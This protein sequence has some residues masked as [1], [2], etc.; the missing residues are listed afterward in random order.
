VEQAF[1]VIFSLYKENSANDE[2]IVSCLE[3]AWP[4][5]L[6]GKLSQVCRPAFYKNSE[7]VI[8]VIESGWD[9]A[10]KSVQLELEKKL[11]AATAGHVRKIRIRG[12]REINS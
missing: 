6:G 5:L 2:W 7:L 3:G 8:D 10:V 12:M 11:A 1:G 9:E 4:K